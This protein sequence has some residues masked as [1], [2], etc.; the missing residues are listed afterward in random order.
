MSVTIERSGCQKHEQV[1]EEVKEKLAKMKAQNVKFCLTTDD[2]TSGRNRRYVNVNCHSK[3][4]FFSFDVPRAQG[5]M[6]AEKKIEL[7]EAR[8]SKTPFTRE[9]IR[10]DPYPNWLR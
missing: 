10:I 3:G 8:L 9:L 1:T 7:I 2:Y 4:D 6:P 5:S